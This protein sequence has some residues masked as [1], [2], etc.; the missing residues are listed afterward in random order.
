MNAKFKFLEVEF[1]SIQLKQS[2]IPKFRGCLADAHPQ[3]TFLHNHDTE[4][5]ADIYRYPL[6]QYKRHKGHP[7]IITYGEAVQSVFQAIM[8]TEELKI[9]DAVYNAENPDIAISDKYIGDTKDILKYKFISPWMG[10]NQDNYIKYI[11]MEEDQEAQNNLLSRILIGNILNLC[12][13]FHVDIENRLQ[14]SLNVNPVKT[15]YKEVPMIGFKGEFDVNCMLPAM[16]GL[17]KGVSRGMGTFVRQK[18]RT[19]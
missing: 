12:Q 10:L 17:G 19:S 6:V 16:C 13:A 8:E 14:V 18:E 5:G 11:E 4:S 2:E 1:G 3:N 7:F 15:M 9:G